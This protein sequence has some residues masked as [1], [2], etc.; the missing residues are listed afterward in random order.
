MIGSVCLFVF[1]KITGKVLKGF[2][3]KFHQ[4]WSLAQLGVIT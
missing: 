2:A 1:S 4:R 3:L